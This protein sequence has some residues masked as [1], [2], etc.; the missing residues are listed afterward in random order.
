MIPP[1]GTLV[2][3]YPN[4]LGQDA[5]IGIDTQFLTAQ[6]FLKG[7][8]SVPPGLHLFHYAASILSGDS[9][10]YGWWFYIEEGQILSVQWDEE[11][12]VFNIE[13]PNERFASSYA[14]MIE[15]P[16]DLNV[17]K[18]LTKNID[19]E[20]LEEY[21][22]CP[23]NPITTATPLLEENMVLLDLLRLKQ[24]SLQ[25][26]DQSQQ[27]L[28]YTIVQE[29]IQM[30]N[31]FGEQLTRTLLDRTWQFDELFGHDPDLF[32]AELQLCFVHFVVLGNLC[33][34]TQWITLVTFILR[35]DTYLKQNT[36]FSN[37]LLTLLRLQFEV[38][39]EEYANVLLP[40]H[41]EELQ[42]CNEVL[43]NLCGIFLLGYESLRDLWCL[44][45]DAA[46]DK[47]QIEFP[48]GSTFDSENFEIYHLN[49]HN[50][51]D[52]DAP[53]VVYA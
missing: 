41:I 18:T 10:R 23:P 19:A 2:F 5:S 53:A 11:R 49:E 14:L 47:F 32:S 35:C 3:H 46:K 26:D 16:E 24:P 51:D 43:R 44:L 7:I 17:W 31:A 9:M 45:E 8:K 22:P 37:S 15:F 12:A 34:C 33:S 29:K 38:L 4:D 40:V 6:A 21:N 25:L 1:K 39:P 20:A 36:D 42:K 28:K 13:Q 48:S 52:E 50:S 27:E 30:K